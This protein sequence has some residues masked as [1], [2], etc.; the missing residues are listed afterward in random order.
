MNEYNFIFV[1]IVSYIVGF[2]KNTNIS[3]QM[4]VKEKVAK[5]QI[6]LLRA[7]GNNSLVVYLVVRL[8]IKC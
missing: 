6:A 7:S 4:E 8:H 2:T 5:I 3:Q 1:L